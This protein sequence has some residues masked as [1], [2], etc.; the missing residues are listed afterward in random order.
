MGSWKLIDY[1]FDE[2]HFRICSVDMSDKLSITVVLFHC[3]VVP[4]FQKNE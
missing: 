3:K 2:R 1:H 4:V